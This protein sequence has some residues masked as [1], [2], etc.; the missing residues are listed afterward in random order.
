MCKI[1]DSIAILNSLDKKRIITYEGQ[2]FHPS[3]LQLMMFLYHVQDTNITAIGEKMGSAIAE[4]MGLT[5]AIA[6][7]MG[8]S[9]GAISQTLSRLQKKGIISKE[10]YPE[11]KNELHIQFTEQGSLLMGLLNKGKISLERKYLRYIKTLSEKDKQIISEF[12][13][14]MVLIHSSSK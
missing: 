11:K 7:K 10:M 4:K 2:K 13:E 5:T 14:K 6:E 3:E 12:L 8:F 1:L 9:K